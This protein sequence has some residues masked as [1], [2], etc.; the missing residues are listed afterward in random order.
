MPLATCRWKVLAAASLLFV[1]AS[2]RAEEPGT[3]PPRVRPETEST[4]QLVALA[5]ARS[6]T[7][8]EMI[9]RIEGS[10]VVVYIR[11]RSFPDSLL[12]GHLGVLSTVAGRRYLV[13]EIA[14]GRIWTEQI[15]TLGHELH[16][17]LEI[18]AHPSIVDS[19]SLAAFYERFGTRTSGHSAGG[20]TYE[21]AGAR[22][23]GQQVRRE[24]FT[25]P[26]KTEDEQ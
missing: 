19:P 21:T 16:H 24:A 8:R 9:E 13:I 4:R 1:A 22:T 7:V 26:V 14:C 20:A 25:S 11:H 5:V 15:A 23:T 3:S 12:Q 2:A 18:A 6:P 10:D 17:A